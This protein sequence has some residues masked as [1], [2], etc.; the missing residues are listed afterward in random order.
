M[1][2]VKLITNNLLDELKDKFATADEIYILVSFLM[3]SGIESIKDSLEDALLNGAEV[4]ICC[5]DYLHVTQ[6]EALETLLGLKAKYHDLNIRLVN[7][8][9]KSFHPKAYIINSKDEGRMIVGSSNLSRSALTSGV[10]WNLSIDKDVNE[11]VYLDALKEFDNIYYANNTVE[12]NVEI[13]KIYTKEYANK[14]VNNELLKNWVEKESNTNPEI[15]RKDNVLAETNEVYQIIEPNEVQ[16]LALEELR[17]TLHDEHERGLVIMATGLG[18]TYLAAFFS[19]ENKEFLNRVLFVAHRE[20]ILTQ[21][22]LTF[23]RVVDGA[24]FGFYNG[25]EKNKEANYIFASVQT[26]GKKKNLNEFSPNNFDLIIVDEFHHAAAPTYKKIIDYFK[27][28]FLLGITATP[29]RADGGD[30]FAICDGNEVFRYE[31]PEAVEKRWLSPYRY[32][33]VYDE[34][35]YTQI[36]WTGK[37]YDR[38]DLELRQLSN[39]IAD[40]VFNAWKNNKQTRT[41]VFC[42]SIRQAEFLSEYFHSQGASCVALHS[43]SKVSRKSA[44][45]SLES[46]D[47][48]IIFTVDLF[49]EGVDIPS[50]DTL[51]FV[52][53]TESLTVFIQQIGRGLRLH[54]GKEYCTIID[55]IG[56]YRNVEMKLSALAKTG[57]KWKNATDLKEFAPSGCTIEFDLETID[58]VNQLRKRSQTLIDRYEDYYFGLKSELGRR[59]NILEFHLKYNL[60]FLID[61]SKG[62][63][64]YFDFLNKIN[65]L[66]Q[67]EEQ[68]LFVYKDWLNEVS[69]TLMNKSYKMVMLAQFLDKGQEKWTNPENIANISYGFYNYIT[70][71][72]YRVIKDG[73]DLEFNRELGYNEKKVINKIKEMPASK[74]SNTSNG[75]VKLDKNNNIIHFDVMVEQEHMEILFNWT[76]EICEYRLHEYF[77]RKPSIKN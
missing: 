30:I 9:G 67:L 52:R 65:E 68:C 23:S 37:E 11:N 18:K 47:I 29:D 73:N 71:K 49:N 59:P 24:S 62:I 26:L 34:I 41:L 77:E 45:N 51:I 76:K 4:F 12:L 43:K 50:V 8:N 31:F 56:N 28:K 64:S 14:A 61:N 7:S 1:S 63:K 33:G 69:T 32:L 74:W 6:P 58:L 21:A 39:D 55:L 42:S 40:K 13:L 10:E 3:K 20:E 17:K 2:N 5:G 66:N 44:I 75:F 72:N 60:K 22:K 25:V 38:E 15:T 57:L 46:Q 36:K 27:P 16:K 48:E 35:D 19:D 53:P 70:S 54:K